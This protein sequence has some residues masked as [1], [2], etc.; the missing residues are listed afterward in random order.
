M[1]AARSP[2]LRVALRELGCW[3]SDWVTV[4]LLSW[5]PLLASVLLLAIFVARTSRDL[6]IVVLDHD[7]SS[8]SRAL[9]DQL[10]A[11]SGVRVAVQASSLHQART[12]VLRGEVYAV[13]EI[14]A[15]FRRD[16][17]RGG[18][19]QV[20]LLLNQQSM[21]AANAI[22]RDVQTVVLTAAGR[23]SAGLRLA[24]GMPPSAVAAAAQPLRVEI[25]PLFNP[26]VDYAAYLGIALLVAGLHCFV[27]LHGV[28]AVAGERDDGQRAWS[29][30]A[31]GRWGA[32]MLGKLGLA[33]IW[34]WLYGLVVLGGAYVWLG[35]PMMSA[36]ALFALGWGGLVAA[37]L[38]LGAVLAMLLPAHIAYSGVSALS[39]PAMAFSGV[40]FPLA[41]MPLV[42]RMFGESLPLTWFLRLQTQLVTER[43]DA[44]LAWPTAGRLWLFALVLVGMSALL[45]A[46][47][48]RGHPP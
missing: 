17:M 14:P 12:A 30:A 7:G 40:T 28:R 23:Q 45:L 18:R 2:G 26:G 4:A 33:W 1:S 5:L 43:V 37:Y 38:G 22:A 44:V 9:T 20:G 48:W 35:L 42:P 21:S 11:T 16:V 31:D 47:R 3:R 8:V 46:R 24:T 19:P 29:Q 36:P 32:A 25:H 6:P 10:D 15:H 27:A 39:A 13:V 34:W 41:A